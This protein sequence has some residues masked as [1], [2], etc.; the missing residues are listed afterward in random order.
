MYVAVN[1]KAV[2]FAGKHHTSIIHQSNIETL[3]MLHLAFQSR[4]QVAVLRED[5]EIEIV[6]IIR[7]SDFTRRIDPNSNR[8]VGDAFTTNLSDIV[9][10]II[11]DLDTVSPVVADEDLLAIIDHNTIGE[12]KMLGASKLVE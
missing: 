6:V 1:V 5:G 8:I 2:V 12:F 11:E 10:L 9:A 3:G 4:H 7:D